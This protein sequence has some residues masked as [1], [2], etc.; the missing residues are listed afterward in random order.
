MDN[1]R[2]PVTP[3]ADFGDLI[4]FSLGGTSGVIWLR[5][6]FPTEAKPERCSPDGCQASPYERFPPHLTHQG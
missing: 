3:N 1:D 2:V 4:R 6:R 5:P